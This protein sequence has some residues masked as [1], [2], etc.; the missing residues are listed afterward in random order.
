MLWESL[1]GAIRSGRRAVET[2]RRIQPGHRRSSRCAPT[3]PSAAGDGRSCARAQ[4]GAAALGGA[5]RPGAP[6]AAEA[7][8]QTGRREAD[9]PVAPGWR[10]RPCGARPARRRS[11]RVAAGWVARPGPFYPAPGRSG[12]PPPGRA[13]LRRTPCGAPVRARRAVLPAREH[14]ARAGR[15]LRGA[16]RRL[17]GADL[18]RRARRRCSSPGPCSRR[19]ARSG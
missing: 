3:C 15:C 2:S 11:R 18:A 8:P 13:R 6:L 5:S 7:A 16:G 17:A 14:L 12:S 9:G 1:A 4:P 10:A 19:S